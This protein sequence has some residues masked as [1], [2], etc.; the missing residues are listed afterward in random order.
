MRGDSHVRFLGGRRRSN[1]LLL[2]DIGVDAASGL[3]HT[4]VGTA[5]IVSDVTQ[6]QALLRGHEA[7]QPQGAF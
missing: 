5:G 6:A 1:A 4:V 3:V 2:P 7:L